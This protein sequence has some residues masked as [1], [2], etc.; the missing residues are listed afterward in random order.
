MGTEMPIK[1]HFVVV[2]LVRMGV[3]EA[4]LYLG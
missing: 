3:V 1:L 4:T 2:G